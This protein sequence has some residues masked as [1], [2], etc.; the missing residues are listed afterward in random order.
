MQKKQI[1]ITNEIMSKIKKGQIKMKPKWYFVLGSA[2]MVLGLASISIVLMFIVRLFMFS[3]RS[4]GPMAD[5]RLQQIISNFPLWAPV[6][7]I[8]GIVGGIYMLK[9]FDFSYKK[10]FYLVVVGI[11]TAIFL[12]G[13]LIDMFDLDRFMFGNR[14]GRGY[15]IQKINK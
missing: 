13:I 12:S 6:L 5:I 9:K 14:F 8:I 3:I 1:D 4:H 11:I 10:N 15:G 7:A 2:S